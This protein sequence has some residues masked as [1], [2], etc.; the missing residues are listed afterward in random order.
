[1][2][3]DTFW[4]KARPGRTDPD[5]KKADMRKRCFL[6]LSSGEA[7]PGRSFGGVPRSAS[8]FSAGAADERGTGEVVFNTGMTGYHEILTDPSYTGQIVTMTYPHAGNYGDLD[9]WSEVGPESL[10]RPNIKAAGLAVRSL[11]E[12]PAP[13]GRI[14][15]D[16]FMARH[17][18]PGIT[19]L[20]TRR[21]TRLIRDRG[22]PIGVIVA[23]ENPE[24]EALSASELEAVHRFLASVPPMEGRNL[25]GDVGTA[26]AVTVNAEGSPHIVLVDCGVKANIMRE[27]TAL[28]AKVTIVPST[29]TAEAILS[30]RPDGVLF[31]NGPGD[32]AVL[33]HPISVAKKLIG[34]RPVFGICL[35][36][37]LISI[38]LGG[39]TYKLPFGH[40]GLNHPVRDMRTGRVIVTSQNHGFAVDESTLPADVEVWFRNAN[41][42]S[43]EGIRHRTLPVLTA[44]FHPEAA[45]GPADSTWIFREFL[46]AI[47]SRTPSAAAERRP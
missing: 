44:Q 39:T 1:M 27:L 31:S 17:G 10:P 29:V 45:P 37:Q 15:L 8:E 36:H 13:A 21:L 24:T 35:G 20:D 42:G 30:H 33:S 47:P 6:V 34:R 28:G 19:E 23:P 43:N 40:H 5:A 12:G 4:R 16:E 46:E 25:I 3:K 32:P 38:A 18:I 41:D 7:F 11:Y 14:R 26:A 9:E 22:N 2:Y